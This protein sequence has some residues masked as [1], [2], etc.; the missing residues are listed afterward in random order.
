[1]HGNRCSQKQA[2]PVRR[3]GSREQPTVEAPPQA[4]RLTKYSPLTT[5]C[6]RRGLVDLVSRCRVLAQTQSS[7]HRIALPPRNSSLRLL[8]GGQ[9]C[10]ELSFVSEAGPDALP[11]LRL[12]SQAVYL[13]P[14]IATSA[15]CAFIGPGERSVSVGGGA[16][17]GARRRLDGVKT[18]GG[19][20]WPGGWAVK[21]ESFQR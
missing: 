13:H 10:Q 6:G 12:A 7:L 14:D 8:I 19:P 11:A 2:W 21:G 1:M 16:D 5:Y 18:R 20:Y 9:A 4:T 17:E 3:C 15:S